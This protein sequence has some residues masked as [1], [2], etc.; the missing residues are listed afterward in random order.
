MGAR[1]GIFFYVLYPAYNRFSE[2]QTRETALAVAQAAWQLHERL[3][4]DK[5]CEPDKID[6]FR[7]D[8]YRT[9]PELEL[10]RDWVETAKHSGLGRS[11]VKLVS[12]TGAENPGGTLVI[13][14]GPVT[15][16]GPFRG[17]RTTVPT[18]TMTLNFDDGKSYDL[19]EVLKRVVE[20][21]RK[22]LF[23]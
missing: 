20:F 19:Q 5:G 15:S 4:H 17:N 7:A 3:W 1:R 10:L 22:E 12:I 2:R 18:C 16:A 11:G 8:L 21:W 23:E 13:N 14:E 9:C 6:D